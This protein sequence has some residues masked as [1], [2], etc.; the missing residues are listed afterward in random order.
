MKIEEFPNP[1]LNLPKE[2]RDSTDKTRSTSFKAVDDYLYSV[3][4][5]IYTNISLDYERS[6]PRHIHA[7]IQKL[8]SANVLRSL[9][10]RNAFV[11][12]FNTRNTVG[13]FLPLKAWFE[14]VG[15]LASILHLLESALSPDEFFEKL[16]PYTLGNKG[17]GG[18]RVGSTEAKSVAD[19]MQKADKYIQKMRRESGEKSG[20]DMK[21]DQFFTDYYDLA[22]NPSH[23]SF[24]AY[25]IVGGLQSGGIWRA[26]APNEVKSGIVEGLPGYGGL[27]MAPLFVQNIC[28]KIA[29]L[30]AEHFAKLGSPKY[31]N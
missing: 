23:P 18:L 15:A 17:K 8:I 24:D 6:D 21:A 3:K 13:I 11:D 5:Y 22:A 16:Q 27:L 26:K 14:T 29:V 7:W 19:M 20:P 4:E 1:K 31:F 25:E 2:L 28:E 12:S 30:E 9:Y 10:I